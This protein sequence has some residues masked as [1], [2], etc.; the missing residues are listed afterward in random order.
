MTQKLFC[1]KYDRRMQ[2]RAGARADLQKS[3]L[4]YVT[5]TLHSSQMLKRV[6]HRGATS[7]ERAARGPPKVRLRPATVFEHP[8]E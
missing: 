4:Q 5:S 7:G 1:A 6:C 3:P 2:I 8:L